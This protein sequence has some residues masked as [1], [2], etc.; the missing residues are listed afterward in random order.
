MY[1]CRQPWPVEEHTVGVHYIATEEGV[2]LPR[3]ND[4]AGENR[5]QIMDLNLGQE[6]GKLHD[7]TGKPLKQQSTVF[8]QT[9]LSGI[10]LV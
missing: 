2:R 7:M 5:G 8:H 4:S 3:A 9:A 10:F 6:N 1:F